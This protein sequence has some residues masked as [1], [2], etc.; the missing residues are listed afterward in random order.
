M[1]IDEIKPLIIRKP[2]VLGTLEIRN[3]NFNNFPRGN[4]RSEG[5]LQ[6]NSFLDKVAV[7]IMLVV[8]ILYDSD[9]C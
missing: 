6:T 8:K 4:Q 9:L 7:M 1:E 5:D 3:K 2:D